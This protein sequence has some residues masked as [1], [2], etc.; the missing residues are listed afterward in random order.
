MNP[1][2]Y[3]GP[4]FHYCIVDDAVVLLNEE[5]GQ[6]I[7][8][9]AELNAAF[10]RATQANHH[11]ETG[12]RANDVTIRPEGLIALDSLIE[13]GVLTTKSD[14][15]HDTSTP[16]LVAA[17][18]LLDSLLLHSKS[19]AIKARNLAAFSAAVFTAIRLMKF[20]RFASTVQRIRMAQARI[21][22]P[23][24]PLDSASVASLILAFRRMRLWTYSASRACL[25]DSLVLSEFLRRN[26]IATSFVF[27]VQTKPFRAHAWVQLGDMV[28][29]DRLERVTCYTPILVI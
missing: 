12:Q 5:T 13:A 3:I 4:H 6:Y 9:P 28:V 17:V 14:E 11:C 22:C 19:R 29:N 18:S 2:Y 10:L 26:G 23:S 1:P 25:F 15:G 7:A 21:P 27:G 24:K 16:A 8:L 20:T